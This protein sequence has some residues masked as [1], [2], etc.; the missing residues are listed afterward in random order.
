MRTAGKRPKALQARR[1][2]PQGSR[3]VPALMDRPRPA[4]QTASRSLLPVPLTASIQAACGDFQEPLPAASRPG[5]PQKNFFQP[6]SPPGSGTL[7]SGIILQERPTATGK[8][9]FLPGS[10]GHGPCASRLVPSLLPL[11][12]NRMEPRPHLMQT[13]A[14]LMERG[15]PLP[16][17]QILRGPLRSQTPTARQLPCADQNKSFRGDGARGKGSLFQKASLPPRQPP[18]LS[19]MQQDILIPGPST[20]GPLAFPAQIGQRCGQQKEMA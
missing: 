9:A 3:F 16:R 11:S 18:F 14:L 19:Y 7:S 5:H 12:L 6:P 2:R 1:I 4:R 10:G 20:P 13:T 8:R 15:C 17:R